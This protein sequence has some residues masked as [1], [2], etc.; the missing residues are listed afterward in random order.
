M[1]N[2]FPVITPLVEAGVAIHW[3]K[4]REKA[5]VEPGW[6]DAP[7]ATLADLRASH[8]RGYN[9]GLRPGEFSRVGDLYLHLFDVDIRDAAQAADAWS[10]LRTMCPVLDPSFPVVISGSG[11]ASRHVYFFSD[12]AF[13]SKKLA[14]SEGF[15]MVFDPRKG[16]D[17]KKWDW[18]IEIFGTGKQVA[19]PP[20]IHPDTGQPYRWERPLDLDLVEMGLAP[21]V[22]SEMIREWTTHRDEP[23]ADE[24]DDRPPLGLSLEEAHSILYDLPNGEWCED[25]DGWL[26]AGM[27]LHHEFAGSERALL[28]WNE[29]SAQ[30]AKYDAKDQARVWKSFKAK[31][32]SVRMATLVKAAQLARFEAMFDEADDVPF[33][34]P[35]PVADDVD[36]LLGEA[37]AAGDSDV[38]DLLG[39][40]PIAKPDEIDWRI[41][42]DRND[43]GAIK[44]TLHN[45]E[46]IVRHDARTKG[47]MRLN[48]F[49]QEVVQVGEPGVFS[50]KRTGPKGIKQLAGPIWKVKDAINGDLWT[51]E[52]DNAIRAIIEAP[53]RQGGYAIKVSDRDLKAA[54]DLV[55]RDM[56]FHPVRDY[57][58]ELTWDGKQR[59]DTMFQRFLGVED[60]PY[61]R[62]VSRLTL[63]GAVVRVFEPAHKFDF[64]TIL[65]GLQGKRKTTFIET[66]AR[67]WFSEL[68]GNFHD[69]KEMVERMQGSWILELPELQGFTKGEVQ[70]I[71]AFVSARKDKVRLAYARRAQEFARQCIF[72]GSTNESK[73][74]RDTTG[75]RRF[76]PII[77]HVAAIDIDGFAAEVDQLWAEAVTAY[78][79]LRTKQPGGTLPLYLSEIEAG[80]EAL[81]MQENRR[82]EGV[83]DGMAGIIG[84]WLDR[85]TR[86][87]LDDDMNLDREPELRNETCLVQIWTEGLGKDRAHYD[88]KAAQMLGRSMDKVEGWVSAKHVNF[89]KYGRQRAYVRRGTFGF[90]GHINSAHRHSATSDVDDLLG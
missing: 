8:V 64:V 66:L 45:V 35:A 53:I 13:R 50:M 1:S 89:E 46:L 82:V 77:C 69:R 36:D 32:N 70:D 71:K 60:T 39:E 49:T 42:L 22:P 18:E 56:A 23:G 25:R 3:L 65:E 80:A 27:A 52:K 28:L 78:R 12:R 76:W 79:A 31:A 10:T 41:K 54:V 51:D 9:V 37:K 16:R 21:F 38:D 20:S 55:A 67:H 44:P 11:G 63:L 33:E 81:E 48:Q 74:L 24:V 40:P 4:P 2:P 58:G 57:L 88:Q 87:D 19:I 86:G 14:H 15:S 73:Y 29:W 72:V 68:N 61:S 34:E 47:V 7:I 90:F 59:L 26:Q 30:S 5:P 43:E 6:S 84:A 75:G 17:V 85:P 83:E 62:G